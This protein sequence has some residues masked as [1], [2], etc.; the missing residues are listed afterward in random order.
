[1]KR[2]LAARPARTVAL[3][4]AAL[5]GGELL[6][7]FDLLGGELAVLDRLGELDLLHVRQKGVLADL[8]EVLP[9]EIFVCGLLPGVVRACCLAHSRHQPFSVYPLGS[10]WTLRLSCVLHRLLKTS[11]LKS[12]S[13]RNR[14][15]SAGLPL[16]KYAGAGTLDKRPR[17]RRGRS[18]ATP[19]SFVAIETDSSMLRDSLPQGKG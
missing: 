19:R 11:R 10:A 12:R 13:D 16:T 18:W 1:M 14:E 17:M 9:H 5:P 4:L 6:G 7:L 8:A 3:E 15:G 2:R